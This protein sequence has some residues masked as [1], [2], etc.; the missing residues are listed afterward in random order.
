MH[1]HLHFR[2]LKIKIKERYG[3]IFPESKIQKLALRRI[4]IADKDLKRQQREFEKLQKQNT[5]FHQE[6]AD[7]ISRYS[8]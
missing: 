5:H 4:K 8:K 2:I 6:I 1:C 3:D 7:K